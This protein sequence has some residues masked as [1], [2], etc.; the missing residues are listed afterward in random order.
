MKP[1]IFVDQKF[2]QVALV[3]EGVFVMAV[4]L[5]VA[6]NIMI[7]NSNSMNKKTIIDYS[8]LNVKECRIIVML[9]QG[10]PAKQ[11]AHVPFWDCN[12]SSYSTVVI[13]WLVRSA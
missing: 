4:L 11:I 8:T 13:P 9:C 10:L 7:F 3:A 12:M 6:D 5:H 1:W 2:Q